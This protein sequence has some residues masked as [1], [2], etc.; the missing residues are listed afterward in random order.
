MDNLINERDCMTIINNSIHA[1]EYK[2]LKYKTES[3]AGQV[4]G[5]MAEYHILTIDIELPTGTVDSYKYFCKHL[6][7]FHKIQEIM[8]KIQGAFEKEDFVYNFFIKECQK[9]CSYKLSFAPECYLAIKDKLFV[10]EDLKKLGYRNAKYPHSYLECKLALR[11]VAQFHALTIIYEEKQ[12]AL[13][14]KNYTLYDKDSILFKDSLYRRDETYL[15]RQW[16]KNCFS[17]VAK[18][19]DL[20]PYPQVKERYMKLEEETYERTTHSTKYLNVICHGD[21]AL[22]NVM[23]QDGDDG[24]PISC[25]LFDYQALRYIPPAHDVLTYLYLV[26]KAEFRKEHLQDLL[27]SY[28][29]DLKKELEKN[30]IKIEKHM[31]EE[32]FYDSCKYTTPQIVLQTATYATMMPLPD[33]PHIQQDQ[34]LYKHYVYGDRSPQCIEAYKKGG[35]FKE[36]IDAMFKELCDI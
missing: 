9:I 4:P 22:S 33:Y 19:I 15:G 6:Q 12:K 25:K 7:M 35:V 28:Y 17:S 11:T 18:L 31:T 16:F 10:F 27:K 13:T 23:F 3:L 5:M 1:P 29:E 26:T 2:L 20:S 32:S 8:G 21:V 34:E 24:Q 36:I 30:D 14:G